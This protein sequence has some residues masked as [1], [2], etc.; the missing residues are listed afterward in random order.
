MSLVSYEQLQQ[1]VGG[2]SPADVCA[3]LARANIRYITGPRGRP[4]T[5]EFAL[6]AAMGLTSDTTTQEDHRQPEVEIG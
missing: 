6:N 3:R 2:A 1:H 5:T 4:F